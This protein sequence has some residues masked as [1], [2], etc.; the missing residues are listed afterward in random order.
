MS[1]RSLFASA[2]S[3]L[4]LLVAGTAAAATL[5]LA[6]ADLPHMAPALVAEAEGFFTAEGL[7]LKV[8]HCVNGRRCLQHLLDGQA[9]LATVADLPL[10]LASHAGMPFEVVVTM[11]TT[12]DHRLV[13]RADRGIAR[14]SDLKGKRIGFVRG[15]SVHYYIDTLLRLHDLDPSQVKLMPLE[16]ETLVDLL[17]RG[18]LDAAA[19]YQPLVHQ[20][21]KRLG[22]KAIL[23]E[24]ARAYTATMNL[25]STTRPGPL[26]DADLLKVIRA[27]NRAC[28]LI[29]SQ[30][31]RAQAVLA[32]VLKVDA[33]TLRAMWPD[34]DFRLTLQQS[35]LTTLE[36]QSR[37]ALRAGLVPAGPAPDFLT[38]VRPGPLR[39]L[40][41]RAVSLVR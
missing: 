22:A 19:L 25:V 35:L 24:S 8:L 30:P 37:W 34:F 10:A 29:D 41:P 18:E 38:R 40:D 36:S 14:M 2:L 1:L 11:A 39:A 12:R 26:A 21:W 3:S 5:T 27:L 13:V 15:T 28:T 20:A 33:P 23:L 9:Q 16:P 32:R 6:V 31:E 7:D 4:T 17:V